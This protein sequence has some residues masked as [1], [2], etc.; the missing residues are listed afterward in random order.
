MKNCKSDE[1]LCCPRCGNNL[2][3]VYAEMNIKSM[4]IYKFKV[5]CPRCGKK[6]DIIESVSYEGGA[7]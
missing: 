2:L 4:K 6:S 1:L 5:R 7:R 3:N